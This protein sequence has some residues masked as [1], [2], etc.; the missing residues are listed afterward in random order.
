MADQQ[1]VDAG[2]VA[3]TLFGH[4]LRVERDGA[5]VPGGV[6]DFCEEIRGM[7]IGIRI[8]RELGGRT[9]M[10]VHEHLG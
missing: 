10:R 7:R 6:R 4:R 1:H 2:R 8:A 3:E 9:N 5:V